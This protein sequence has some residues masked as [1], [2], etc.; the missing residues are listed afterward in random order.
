MFGEIVWEPG[1]SEE[2]SQRR[3]REVM[4]RHPRPDRE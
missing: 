2:E 4:A 3:T 1:M